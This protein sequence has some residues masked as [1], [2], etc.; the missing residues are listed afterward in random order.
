MR[1]ELLAGGGRILGRAIY[2]HA[3]FGSEDCYLGGRGY[4]F[5]LC[6]R[7]IIFVLRITRGAGSFQAIKIILPHLF[8]PLTKIT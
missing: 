4:D 6:W 1:G 3:L 5:D 2:H 8:L 7:F